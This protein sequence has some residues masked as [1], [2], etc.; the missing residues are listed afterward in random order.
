MPRLNSEKMLLLGTMV[1]FAALSTA[2][3]QAYIPPSTVLDDCRRSQREHEVELKQCIA[4]LLSKNL[5]Y[6]T[7]QM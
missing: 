4:K 7:I 6:P 1:P 2:P 3:T 5:L